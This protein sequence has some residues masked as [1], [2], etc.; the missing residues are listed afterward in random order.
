MRSVT[1][2]LASNFLTKIGNYSTE[3][4]IFLFALELS[5]ENYTLVGIIYL[6][7]FIP[8]LLCGP[9]GGWLADSFNKKMLMTSVEAVR[10]ILLI[11]LYLL[12]NYQMVSVTLFI[13]ILSLLT[14]TRTVFQ[15][16]FQSSIP[17]LASQ[18]K[19]VKINSINQV[20]EEVGSL[21]G[22]L[23]TAV[24]ISKYN[25]E[26]VLLIDALSYFIS[27][28]LILLIQFNFV[29]KSK[30]TLRK[31]RIK[32][33][34][35]ETL[36]HFRYLTKFNQDLIQIIV[37]SSI[38]ILCVASLLRFILPAYIL[39]LTDSEK[40][41]SYSFSALALGTIIGGLTFSKLQFK[42]TAVNTM[43]SWLL[44]GLLFF[45]LAFIT[46]IEF[47]I[48]TLVIL[49]FVGAFVDIFLVSFIQK[50]SN[51]NNIGKNFSLF[52]TLANTGESAS[53]ILGGFLAAISLKYA[54]VI[55]SSFVIITPLV[56]RL[57]KKHQGSDKVSTDK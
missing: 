29:T 5:E 22:P 6:I 47:I 35:Y 32:N 44:Y 17:L 28:F 1:L 16:A 40:L 53:G 15:P 54:L 30:V 11:S 34:L 42:I 36:N 37:K 50:R 20:L 3:V 49:G 26:A 21:L 23:L 41:V 48:L 24:I 56:N 43:K 25:K 46:K 45:S 31:F 19:L 57:N 33:V 51:D 52:S 2:L 12:F 55:L 9:I 38:C 27:F 39:N 14:I 7:R 10:C 18:D 13:L 4:I 8:Y